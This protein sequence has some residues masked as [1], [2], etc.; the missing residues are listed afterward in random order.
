MIARSDT[1]TH[2]PCIRNGFT[3]FP[4]T[5]PDQSVPMHLAEARSIIK[6]TFS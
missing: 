4:S 3:L 2:S 5:V 1:R 6:A